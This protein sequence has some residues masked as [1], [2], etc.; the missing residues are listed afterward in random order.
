MRKIFQIYSYRIN[1][2]TIVVL[3][4]SLI[5]LSSFF[6]IQIIDRKTIK[7]KVTNQGFREINIYG[8]RGKILDSNNKQLSASINKYDFWVN[9]NKLFDENKIIKLFSHNFN[10][11]ES[12]YKN[13]LSKKSNFIKIEKNI[14]FLQC[15]N[16]L[17]NINDI[18]GLNVEKNSKRYYPYNSL[19]CQTLGYV[20]LNGIGQ[21][22]I[23]GH[24]NTI[25][26]GDTN[27]I[28]LK[29]GAKGK[30]YKQ[31]NDF[32]NQINGKNIQLTIDINIQ[33][34][35]QEEL[36][37]TINSTQGKSANGI[38]INPFTG[39]IIAM[40][41]VPD[42]DPN[43][44]YKY[45]IDY[46]KNRVISDS[47]EPGSTFKIIPILA[48]LIKDNNS[49]TN[50]YYCE[51]G[52][53]NLTNKNK[54]RDH[55]PNDTL[56]LKEIFIHSSNIGI[57]KTVQDL[58]N[59]D[60]YKLCKN[61]GFGTKTGLPFKNESM[62]KLRDL[63]N[64]SKTSKTYISIGQE[65]GVTNIQLALAYC[66]I[67]NG[68]YLIRPNI[69]KKISDNSIIYKRKIE[70]IRQVIDLEQSKQLLKVLTE[71]VNFGTAKNLN[72]KGY[73]VGGKTGT[74]QKFINGEYSHSEF[75]ASFA[76]IFPIDNPKY[77]IIVSIDSPYYGKH[78]ANESAVPLSKNIINRIIIYDNSLYQ[79]HKN[80]ILAKNK[81]INNDKELIYKSSIYSKN[82]YVKEV[83]NLRGKSLKEALGIANS[84]GI[85]LDPTGLSGKIVW[86]SL[87]PGSKITNQKICK[88]RL[89]I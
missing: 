63:K 89:S 40:A 28:K 82:S 86:Q 66:A 52:I 85:K 39:D 43:R 5:I 60:I 42:F 83:P 37:K 53:Y 2:L 35:L 57:S 67:A 74:A 19:A 26:S 71:V 65:I 15:K 69:I 6:K 14:L 58:D 70:P 36:N 11:P 61:F 72:L 88:V 9:T 80:L 20:D 22:G 13:I 16:I 68:G 77:V 27:K 64:W 30:Y 25:L 62:G 24:F 54:L 56:S 73:N 1:N 44:Y 8:S 79:H 55:E 7:Q 59:M 78:W 75:I 4:F 17:D 50:K 49:L 45:N 18:E 81:K 47:Y 51:N 32:E 3:L 48:S 38:I 41:S 34:I 31:I 10:K 87:K 84:I 23:E 21:V 12:H 76:S 29:K 33:K 46:Y